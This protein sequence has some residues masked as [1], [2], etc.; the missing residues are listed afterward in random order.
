M[1]TTPVRRAAAAGVAGTCLLAAITLAGAVRERDQLPAAAHAFLTASI[2]ASAVTTCLQGAQDELFLPGIG[3]LHTRNAVEAALNQLRSCDLQELSRA[4][5]SVHLPPAAPV[6]D[7]A[8]RQARAAIVTGLATLRQVAVDARG[9]DLAM[10][11]DVRSS[12]D[13][14]QVVLAYRSAS[15]GSD[16]AYALAEKALALLGQPQSTVSP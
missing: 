16:A 6:T 1:T 9:A 2:S 14:T 5:D 7:Q 12:S 11:A 15:A 8:R 10:A 4:I 3:R 13:G